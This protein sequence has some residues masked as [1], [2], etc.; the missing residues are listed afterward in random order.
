L[1]LLI[2]LLTG[3]DQILHR[4]DDG[5]APQNVIVGNVDSFVGKL[6]LILFCEEVSRNHYRDAHLIARLL[7]VKIG[8]VVLPG[9]NEWPDRQGMD[10]TQSGCD[11]VGKRQAQKIDLWIAAEILKWQHGNGLD[12]CSRRYRLL[13]EGAERN[14]R[15]DKEDGREQYPRNAGLDLGASLLGGLLSE[16]GFDLL[17]ALGAAAVEIRETVDKLGR[18]LYAP[19]RVPTSGIGDVLAQEWIVDADFPAG[20]KRFAKVAA[21][22]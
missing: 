11:F 8:S 4:R 21:T 1:R 16:C 10:I 9:G 6:Q 18:T 7:Q 15:C 13:V 22:V 19:R 12:T 2:E 3:I 20:G 5:V 17:F 14:S